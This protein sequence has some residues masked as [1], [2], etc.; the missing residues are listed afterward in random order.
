MATIRVAER[1]DLDA[2]VQL[3]TQ[4]FREDS[5]SR[6]PTMNPDWPAEEGAEYFDGLIAAEGSYVLV[7]EHDGIVVGS[8]AG[9][10]DRASTLR[11]V[12]VATLESVCVD[13][14]A[15]QSGVG[16][17]LAEAFMAWAREHG[18]RR[19]RVTAYTSND[20]AIRFYE[21]LGFAPHELTLM[22]DLDG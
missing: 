12:V 22:R 2:L 7:A 14:A 16:G 1:A 4:L 5:G 8:L 3:S 13:A 18:A 21:R 19:M 17:A 15:R 6:D 9:H 10:L 20:G 11:P